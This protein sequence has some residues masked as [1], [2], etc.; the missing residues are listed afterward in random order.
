LP[1]TRGVA[2]RLAFQIITKIVPII[3]T[4]QFQA[5]WFHLTAHTAIR[6]TAKALGLAIPDKLLALADEVIE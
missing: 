3:L 6:L 1:E 5:R 2:I 4:Y